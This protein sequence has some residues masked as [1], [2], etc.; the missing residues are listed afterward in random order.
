MAPGG[1]VMPCCLPTPGRSSSP[2]VRWFL[3]CARFA[4]CLFKPE[5]D[6]ES[7][8]TGLVE[9]HLLVCWLS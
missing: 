8:P 1:Q 6:L 4:R 7:E 5:I 9:V 3:D 2:S